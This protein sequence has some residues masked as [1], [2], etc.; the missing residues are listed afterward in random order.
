[1]KLDKPYTNQQYAALAIYCNENGFVIEDKG[2]YLE[3]VNPPEPSEDELKVRVRNIRNGYLEQT[4]KY[5]SISDFPITDE[6]REKYKAYRVYLRDYPETEDWW[7]A[8]PKTFEEWV[9]AG[10]QVDDSEQV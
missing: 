4:D 3:S 1:M 8:N 9:I 10:T 2:D 7:K 6:E 5:L